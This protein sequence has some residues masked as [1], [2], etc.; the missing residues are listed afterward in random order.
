MDKISSKAGFKEID[1]IF[2][3]SNTALVCRY[4]L[5]VG[6]VRMNKICSSF[7]KSKHDLQKA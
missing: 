7:V 3:A 5:L 4:Q 6:A 2:F 1:S